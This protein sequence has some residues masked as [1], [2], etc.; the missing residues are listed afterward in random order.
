MFALSTT[1]PFEH[2]DGLLDFSRS[3]RSSS[4]ILLMSISEG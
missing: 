2:D 3:A 1:D 4:N